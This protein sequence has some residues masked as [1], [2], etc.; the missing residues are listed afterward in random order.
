M[1]S[2][3][4]KCV[5]CRSIRGHLTHLEIVF[6][7]DVVK[8]CSPTVQPSLYLGEQQTLAFYTKRVTSVVVA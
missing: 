1:L 2:E 7:K 3:Q 4:R 6:G 8:M 5:L